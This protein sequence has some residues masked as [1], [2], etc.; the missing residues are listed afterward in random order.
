MSDT[1]WDDTI[2]CLVG[3]GVLI[4]GGYWAYDHLKFVPGGK[5]N[6]TQE[7]ETAAYPPRPTAD[8]QLGE[9]KNGGQW[10]LKSTT[11]VGPRERRQG[12]VRISSKKSAPSDVGYSQTLYLV[13]C[14]ELS[15]KILSYNSYDQKDQF[16]SGKD[17]Q[18]A[19]A[20]VQHFA[21]DS[22]G[23]TV[24]DTLCSAQFDAPPP[25]TIGTTK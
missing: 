2:G 23:S 8:M 13:N 14:P 22:M 17:T 11:V 19:D 5:S 18:E 3:A 24:I 6:P 7:V 1:K 4:W 21:P 9:D 15:S 25:I 12:W 20:P 16:M 10:L